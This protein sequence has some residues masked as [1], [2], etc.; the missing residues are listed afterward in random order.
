MSAVPDSKIFLACEGVNDKA[1]LEEA[2]RM[3]GAA[4]IVERMGGEGGLKKKLEA[5]AAGPGL[6]AVNVGAFAVFLDADNDAKTKE[7]LATESMRAV[8]GGDNGFPHGEIKPL[9][10]RGRRMKAGVF[11]M[12]GGGRGGALET[13]ILDSL[14]DKMPEAM[15]C[16]RDFRECA[17][18]SGGG[19]IQKEAKKEAQALLSALPEYCLNFVDMIEAGKVDFAA[20]AFEEL[21]N[22]ILNLKRESAKP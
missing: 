14:R 4:V 10:V 3:V 12:P 20:P 11:I 21:R 5:I 2:A 13:M 1:V 16:V 8:F 18:K 15:A 7:K 9:D 17:Q 6:F 19:R 22:F